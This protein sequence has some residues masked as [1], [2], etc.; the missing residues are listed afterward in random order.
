MGCACFAPRPSK[1]A[2]DERF[3]TTVSELVHLSLSDEGTGAGSQGSRK[4]AAPLA[5]RAR[6]LRTSLDLVR[7]PRRHSA[8]VGRGGRTWSRAGLT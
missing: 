1:V 5:V 3:Q 2:V 7:R 8:A 4:P 6:R